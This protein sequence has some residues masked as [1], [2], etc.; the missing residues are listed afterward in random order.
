MKL[1]LDTCVSGGARNE[2]EAGGH[3][4]LWAGTWS[5]D[6]GDDEILAQAHAEHRILVTLA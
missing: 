4:V 6:P 2:I 5:V 3:D 1:T